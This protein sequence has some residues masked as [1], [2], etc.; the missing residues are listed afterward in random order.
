MTGR[1]APLLPRL[2]EAHAEVLAHPVDGEAVLVV[3]GQHGL[4][5]VDHLP[6]AGGA[7]RDGVDDLLA[8]EPRLDG[9]VQ[10]LGQALD[11]AGDADLVDHLGQLAGADRP[12]PADRLAIGLHDRLGAGEILLVAAAH[13]GEHAVLGAGLAARDGRVD[14]AD[15]LFPADAMQLARNLG[16]G[17]GV[18]DEDGA[19]PHAG[20]GAGVAQHDRAQIVVIADAG[21][22]ELGALGRLGRGRGV[23]AAVLL[24]PRLRPWPSLRL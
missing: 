4:V 17:G 10:R 14:E 8:V 2:V 24:G 15:A 6:R 11:E 3:V 20:E 16:G 19:L 5:A 1:R 21:H 13:D 18:V 12:E 7:A 23:G 22:D 9:E